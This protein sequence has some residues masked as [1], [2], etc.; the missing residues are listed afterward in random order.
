MNHGGELLQRAKLLLAP[1]VLV[2]F[3]PDGLAIEIAVKVEDPRLDGDLVAV[4]DGGAA[5]T[6]VTAMWLSRPA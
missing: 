1:K 3:H 4:V 5:P 2:K 6:L